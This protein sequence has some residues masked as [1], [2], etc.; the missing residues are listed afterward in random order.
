VNQFGVSFPALILLSLDEHRRRMI[1]NFK[2]L[3]GIVKRIPG[4]K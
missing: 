2:G 4:E 1:K 3:Q